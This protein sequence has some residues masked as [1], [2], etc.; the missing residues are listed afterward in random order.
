MQTR[1]QALLEVGVDYVFSILINIGGQLLFYHGVATARRVTLF[2]GL[3]LGLAFIRRFATRRVFEA[4]VPAGAPQPRW[5]SAVEAVS[6]TALGFAMTVGLQMLIY[7]DVAT[8]LRASSL[9]VGI[10][11]FTMLRRYLLRRLFAAWAL[12]TAL[13]IASRIP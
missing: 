6:D 1:R 5:H 13:G 2:A 9:T 7:G 3:V 4:W 12:R 10:Y 8:L 11:G